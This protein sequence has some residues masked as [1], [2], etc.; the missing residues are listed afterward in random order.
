MLGA[1]NAGNGA[2]MFQA[3]WVNAGIEDPSSAVKGKVKVIPFPVFEDGKGTNT[4]IF[5]GAV[6]GF[7]INQNTKHSKEAVEF[8]M[9][10]SGDLVHKVSWLEPACQAGKQIHSTRPACPP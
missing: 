8:L 6:D 1:F 9:Y 4:E 7:Y 3:N 10:L 5:G 2:M